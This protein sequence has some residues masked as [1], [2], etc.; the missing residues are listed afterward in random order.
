MR[1]LVSVC[2]MLTLM[3]VL[4]LTAFAEGEETQPTDETYGETHVEEDT[5]G[6]FETEPTTELVQDG[7]D[8]TPAP[9]TGELSGIGETVDPLFGFDAWWKE[10]ALPM[11][12]AFGLSGGAV[13]LEL[14]PLMVKIKKSSG[15]F[16]S[17]SDAIEAMSEA[18]VAHDAQWK[19]EKE[20]LLTL[21]ATERA[22]Q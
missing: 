19:R 7:T 21:F 16:D 5:E 18:T 11:V 3:V 22:E 8:T 20:E 10:K 12:I 1:K 15:R 13:L 6:A 4:P 17:S 9:G 2:L 14:L